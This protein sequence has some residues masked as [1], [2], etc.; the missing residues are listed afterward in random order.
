MHSSRDLLLINYFFGVQIQSLEESAE[1]LRER[2]LKFYKGCRKYTYAYFSECISHFLSVYNQFIILFFSFIFHICS[3]GL[4]EGYDGDIAFAS[5]LET[6]GGG[7]NDPISVAF[8]G[9]FL[10]KCHSKLFYQLDTDW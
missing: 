4:G 10:L 3:E 8:G 9:M 2:S 7:H 6:F 1:T 5:A